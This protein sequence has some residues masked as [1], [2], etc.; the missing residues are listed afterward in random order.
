[1]PQPT[2][3][4]NTDESPEAIL[5]P[6]EKDSRKSKLSRRERKRNTGTTCAPQENSTPAIASTAGASSMIVHDKTKS[7]SH[8]TKSKKGVGKTKMKVQAKKKDLSVDN[9]DEESKHA[10]ATEL[11]RKTNSKKKAQQNV[12]TIALP[13]APIR[14]NEL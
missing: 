4:A 2:T 3:T 14:V 5:I 13:A 1:L 7:I 10:D 12:N 6:I 11:K 8:D 9:V